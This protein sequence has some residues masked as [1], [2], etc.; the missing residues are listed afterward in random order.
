MENEEEYQKLLEPQK[1]K[2]KKH[3]KTLEKNKCV[4]FIIN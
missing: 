1:K 2:L 3:Q 4:V